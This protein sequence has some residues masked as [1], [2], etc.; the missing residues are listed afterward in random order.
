MVEKI[1][2]GSYQEYSS[3]YDSNVI[4]TMRDGIKLSSDIF[5]P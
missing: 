5:F 4:M 3:I 2:N 1:Y